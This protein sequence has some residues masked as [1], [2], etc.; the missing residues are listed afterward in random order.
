M[1]NRYKYEQPPYSGHYPQYMDSADMYYQEKKNFEMK[2]QLRLR[3][4][5]QIEEK[6]ITNCGM[7]SKE[8]VERFFGQYR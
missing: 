2:R 4:L 1:D 5:K 7:T 3:L 6:G 8:Q